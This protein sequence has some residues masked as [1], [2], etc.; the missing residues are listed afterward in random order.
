MTG[1]TIGNYRVIAKLGEG[2]M[3][4][5]YR[6]IDTMLE[7]DAALK[8]LKPEIAAQPGIVERF[9]SEAVLLA[10]LNHPAIAQLYT[11]FKDGEEYYMAMEYVAGDTLEALIQ[12]N[13]AIPY[14]RALAYTLQI[15]QGIGHAHSMAILHRDLKPAN[16]MLTPA[17]KVKIMDFG[18]ARVLGAAGMTRDG[19]V[20]GTL[21]YL[22]P[23][24]IRGKQDDPRSDLYSVGVVLYQMLTGHLPFQAD[25]DYDLLTAHIQEQPARPR[26]I[27]VSLPPDLESVLMRSLEKDPD[28]R[29]ADAAAF[30]AAIAEVASAT[31]GYRAAK[32]TEAVELALETR[33]EGLFPRTRTGLGPDSTETRLAFLPPSGVPELPAIPVAAPAPI[34]PAPA[35]ARPMAKLQSLLYDKR[36]AAVVAVLALVVSGAGG[37][38]LYRYKFSPKAAPARQIAAAPPAPAQP[39]PSK[40][41]EP[42]VDPAGTDSGPAPANTGGGLFPIGPGAKPVPGADTK[43]RPD[44]GNPKPSEPPAP[45]PAVTPALSPEAHHNAI[46]A[47]DQ[48]EG[49]ATG[50]P[51]ARPIQMAG[52]LAAL[53]LGGASM[54]TDFEDAVG[55]R[56]V[57][58]Q[59]TPAQSDTLRTAGAPDALLKLIDVNYRVRPAVAAA[60]PPDT[61]PPPVVKPAPRIARLSEMKSIFVD[62]DQEE[63]RN[64]VREEIAK[65]LAGRVKLM[66]GQAGADAAIKVTLT[67][68]ESKERAQVRAVVVDAGTGAPL[69]D[70]GA[71]D[72]KPI[73]GIFHGDALKRLASRIVKDLKDAMVRK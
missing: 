38:L 20:M 70:Q 48:T 35:A 55:R 72:H 21:E 23:E 50:D 36:A 63:M 22:A 59:L 24:R 39:I 61:P 8:S 13:G 32:K 34:S 43:P 19:R 27:G 18:I 41:A 60:K 56:G 10:K 42:V 40:P 7:R 37:W 30:E 12:N 44:G 58:F 3:G 28:R 73:I 17:E 71:V 46:A 6:A 1:R 53:K 5:V 68:A 33:A 66:D 4:K 47:L 14:P 26:D 54:A 9:R 2:G 31:R 49:P 29:Y 25:S 16:I 62:C 67:G 64:A 51:G 52:L 45:P 11:F 65:Q 69:W 15:L 57:N